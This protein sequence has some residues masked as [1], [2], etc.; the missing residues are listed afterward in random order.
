[1]PC[2]GEAAFDD[3]AVPNGV[4]PVAATV[5]DSPPLLAPHANYTDLRKP[6]C[7]VEVAVS[8]KPASIQANGQIEAVPIPSS[9]AAAPPTVIND[10]SSS[11]ATSPLLEQS[12]N[13]R[14]RTPV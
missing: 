6:A 13:L 12:E 9:A 14:L 8:A 10:N 1:M 2:T 11:F 5:C 3:C 7:A 4:V